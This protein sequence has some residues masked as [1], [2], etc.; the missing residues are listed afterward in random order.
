MCSIDLKDG[1]KLVP[2]QED[3]EKAL[4]EITNDQDVY[5]H[6]STG[7]PWTD[8]MIHPRH[9][10]YLK[11]NASNE[12]YKPQT[13]IKCW[14]LITPEGEAIG[15]GGFI[16][17]V[18]CSPEATQPFFAIKGAYQHKGEHQLKLGTQSAYALLKW[19]D[20]NIG[21]DKLLRCITL[22]NNEATKHLALKNSFELLMNGE[23]PLTLKFADRDCLVFERK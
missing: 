16:P 15:R 21:S 17:E 9:L 8:E 20:E 10:A 2:Y 12:D 14:V 19:F 13:F 3:Y 22:S 4:K 23:Q 18:R 7:Q 11:G 1:Y 5:P 6:L